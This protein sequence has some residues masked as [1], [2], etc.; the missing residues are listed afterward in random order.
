VV[1]GVDWFLG[2][3]PKVEAEPG[4]LRPSLCGRG[5]RVPIQPEPLQKFPQAVRITNGAAFC[6][7]RAKRFT[8]RADSNL[9]KV[10]FGLMARIGPRQFSRQFVRETGE[11]PAKAVERLR[12]EEARIRVSASSEPIELIA[13]HVGFSDPE[14]MRRA[15]LRLFGQPPQ[16]MRRLA[17]RSASQENQPVGWV[18]SARRRMREN[19]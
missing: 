5:R 9:I 3:A 1:E 7:T 4:R 12:A 16:A 2:S 18:P 11:T 10:A 17:R 13:R 19:T 14:R 8:E 15:F 6:A